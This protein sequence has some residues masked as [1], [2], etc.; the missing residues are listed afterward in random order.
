M[1]DSDTQLDYVKRLTRISIALSAEK[2][3][4]RLM[5]MIVDEARKLTNA[6][7]G[8]LYV[9]SDDET[10]LRFAIIQN[11]TLGTRIG[12]TGEPVT[13]KP[14]P[15]RRPDGTPNHAHVCAYAAL[16]GRIVDI[17]DVYYAQ[18]HDFEGMREF[19]V[20]TGYRSQSMLVVPLRNHE[21]EIIGVL[22]LLNAKDPATG[23]ITPFSVASRE[24]TASLASQ[25]AVALTNNRLI[26]DVEHLLESFIKAIAT[27]IDEKSPYTGGHVRR[28]AELT[29]AIAEKIDEAATGP[30][31]KVH[32]TLDQMKE[33]QIAAWLHDLG[34]VTTPEYVVDKATKLATIYD[35][36]EVV[37]LRFE[38]L[39]RQAEAELLAK[40]LAEQGIRGVPP[41]IANGQVSLLIGRD[42]V[43]ASRPD[44]GQGAYQE[45]VKTL[46]EEFA[47]LARVN[48]GS[49]F[50]SD[51][52]IERVRTIAKRRLVVDG[53][54]RPLLSEEE[55]HNLTVRKGTLTDEERGIIN[56]HAEVTH[57]MLSQLPFPKKSKNVPAYASTHHEKLD[58]A[59]YPLGL[60][61]DQLPLQSRII[62]LADVFEALTAKDRPY[63]AGLTLSEA[64]KTLQEMVE[65]N[66][67]DR[68]LFELFIR[69][70]IHRGYAARE[71]VPD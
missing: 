18:G 13:W 40:R 8:S 15:L 48:A 57:D 35:R 58:G 62:A 70:G 34:K 61:A 32:F 24:I 45:L 5:E 22:Q 50:M 54:P 20:Q 36:I 38:L 39:K 6:D 25:A 51:A 28:V 56:K 69:E 46:D 7:G 26:H 2:N 16:T 52:E 49:E 27:A 68:D 12:G 21:H 30:Y 1:R 59:G 33:L 66:H 55:V 29:M 17:P 31:A 71:S 9:V 47:F 10:E 14:V 63:R 11:E 37:R 43:A 65:H 41:P 3:L 42:E 60:K 64:V 67:L 4:D 23:D 44:A 53:E 19:D